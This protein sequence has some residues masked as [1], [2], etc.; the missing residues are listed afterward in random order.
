MKIMYVITQ[1][2]WGGA[3][4]HVYLLIE[5]Q[6]KEQREV[7]LVV[8]TE[9]RLTEQVK[10]NFPRVHVVVINQMCRRIAPFKDVKT[11]IK[12][13]RLL[14]KVSPDLVHLHSAKAGTIGRLASKG[15]A[16]TVYTVHGWAFTVG[17]SKKRAL[18][19]TFIERCL[20]PLTTHYICVSQFDYRLGKQKR[21]M[22]M[23]HNGEVIHNGVKALQK[24]AVVK[25]QSDQFLVTMAARFDVPKRQDLLI[26]AIA[27]V[28]NRDQ[29][30]L[31]LLGDGPK[32]NECK[33]IV[34]ELGLESSV[35]FKGSVTNVQDYYAK[36]DAVALIS[37]Y[38]ALPL[39]IVEGMALGL[40]IIASNVGGIPELCQANGVLVKNETRSITRALQ[41]MMLNKTNCNTMGTLSKEMYQKEYTVK[42][43]LLKTDAAYAEARN[44]WGR[45]Y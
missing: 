11:V 30:K 20:Q 12:L 34:A 21:L 24:K 15:I 31:I 9:G 19:A 7:W 43:M 18:M 32:L 33:K 23:H 10:R 4:S 17:V 40:P 14:K 5:Q 27:N 28:P 35:I 39:C 41:K 1:G 25:D 16:P 22:N 44:E 8:G 42:R 2:T 26:R 37:D 6:V 13:R 45:R 36:S 38:E 3:Q 29:F